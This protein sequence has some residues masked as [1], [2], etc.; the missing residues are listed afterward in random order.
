MIDPWTVHSPRDRWT[1]IDIL[2]QQ[3][4]EQNNEWALALGRWTDESG[5]TRACL[6]M[7]WNGTHTLESKG[8]PISRGYPTWFILP[9]ESNVIDSMMSLIPAEKHR[10]VESHLSQRDNHQF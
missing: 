10:W 5:T 2:T 1:L 6:A 9:S 4:G 8:N 3:G 7:R